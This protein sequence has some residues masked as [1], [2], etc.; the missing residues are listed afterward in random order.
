[1]PVLGVDRHL[2]D[3]EWRRQLDD[4]GAFGLCDTSPRSRYRPFRRSPTRMPDAAS[5]GTALT[6]RQAS[7]AISAAI[8]PS[9]WH[10]AIGVDVGIGRIGHRRDGEVTTF[11]GGKPYWGVQLRRQRA[12]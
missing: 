9:I 11:D 3:I 7:L 1:M 5:E 4:A 6:S 8:A 2:I 12:C 10:L